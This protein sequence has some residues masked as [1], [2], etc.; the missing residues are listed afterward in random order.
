M[1]SKVFISVASKIDGILPRFYIATMLLSRYFTS[2]RGLS[3][4]LSGFSMGK[5]AWS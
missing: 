5:D 2:L 4:R 1:T 3:I